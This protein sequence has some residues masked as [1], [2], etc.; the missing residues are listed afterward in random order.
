MDI[1]ITISDEQ[2]ADGLVVSKGDLVGICT[3]LVTNERENW[4]TIRSHTNDT[5]LLAK[6]KAAPKAIRD[7]VDAIALPVDEKPADDIVVG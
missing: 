4:A 1:T 7:A 3:R 5:D 6:V 2:A